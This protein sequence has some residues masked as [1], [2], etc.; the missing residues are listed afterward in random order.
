MYQFIASSS[1]H[2]FRAVAEKVRLTCQRKRPPL[3]ELLFTSSD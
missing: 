3:K 2:T 1:T